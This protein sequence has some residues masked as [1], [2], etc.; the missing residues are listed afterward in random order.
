M[1]CALQSLQPVSRVICLRLLQLVYPKNTRLKSVRCE[2]IDYRDCCP[3]CSFIDAEDV[4]E[5]SPPLLFWIVQCPQ[6]FG[7]SQFLRFAYV[8]MHD[9]RLI[10]YIQPPRDFPSSPKPN[11]LEPHAQLVVGSE[12]YEVIR[13]H[14][15]GQRAVP[16]CVLNLN[17][18]DWPRCM[19][20]TY[21]SMR[22]F[23]DCSSW[24]LFVYL[25]ARW[26]QTVHAV[27]RAQRGL[28]DGGAR[29]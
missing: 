29:A 16:G 25:T 9:D 18:S 22:E 3:A 14:L 26:W 19:S 4:W 11:G 21:H 6:C 27:K 10:G 8:G 5:L 24:M 13:V 20:S 23:S 28:D 7:P 15:V 17:V 1:P 2:D 12:G